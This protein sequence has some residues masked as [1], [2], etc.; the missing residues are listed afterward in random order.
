M[1]ITLTVAEMFEAAR[2]A[3]HNRIMQRDDSF[4]CCKCGAT[5]WSGYASDDDATVCVFCEKGG[6]S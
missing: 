4:T 5:E 1:N 3:E 6:K 2:V